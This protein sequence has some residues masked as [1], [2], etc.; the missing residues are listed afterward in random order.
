MFRFV[1]K[2]YWLQDIRLL[3]FCSER[4]YMNYLTIEFYILLLITFVL[5]YLIPKKWQWLV[6]LIGSTSFYYFAC[7]HWQQIFVFIVSITISYIWGV[8]LN[9]QK[10]QDSKI[11]LILAVLSSA[12]PL[13]T[14]KFLD[15]AK[16]S[17]INHNT[18]SILIPIG[19]S[20]Y[21]LQ[22]IVTRIKLLL[23]KTI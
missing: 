19:L 8:L 7:N 1:G 21:S 2:L 4:L 10:F 16:L 23:K 20:F 17:G 13:L 22:M 9:R 18:Y 14:V 12:G 5:Y 3:I 6:L 15:F 11:W